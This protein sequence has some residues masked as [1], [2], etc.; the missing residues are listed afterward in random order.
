MFNSKEEA[1]IFEDKSLL[2]LSIPR[3]YPFHQVMDASH[4][5]LQSNHTYHNKQYESAS[6]WKLTKTTSVT[7]CGSLKLKRDGCKGKFLA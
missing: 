3:E 1:F 2:F 4:P 5:A 7:D 6:A